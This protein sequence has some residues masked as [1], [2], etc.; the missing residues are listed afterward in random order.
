MKEPDI[1]QVMDG[2][3]DGRR[4]MARLSAGEAH[5]Q[6]PSDT[7]FRK[8]LSRLGPYRHAIAIDCRNP[9]SKIRQ[10]KLAEDA[11]GMKKAEFFTTR[12]N[13]RHPFHIEI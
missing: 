7:N 13:G 3:E 12:V 9:E 2:L 10:R 11:D 6:R 1:L 8:Q 5:S 4:M